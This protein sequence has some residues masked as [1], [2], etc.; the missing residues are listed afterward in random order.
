MILIARGK[1]FDPEQRASNG[2]WQP[3]STTNSPISFQMA[4]Q[5]FFDEGYNDEDQSAANKNH[6]LLS[7]ISSEQECEGNSLS[8]RWFA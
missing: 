7:S 2:H 5:D 1:S 8:F 3:T 6:D 4:S